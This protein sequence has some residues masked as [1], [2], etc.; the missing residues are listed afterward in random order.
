MKSKNLLKIAAFAVALSTGFV[1]CSSD[2]DADTTTV[3][4]SQ[5]A[6]D[7]ACSDWKTARANWENSEA[8]LFGAA[9]VYSIDPHTDTWPV[10]ANDLA[11]VLRDGISW[12]GICAFPS[13]F[14]PPHQSVDQPRVQ[15]HLC[16]G[17]RPLQRHCHVGS[18]MGLEG[19]QC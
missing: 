4:G 9:D 10:A 13:R 15:L 8:F 19:E 2:D 16:C 5:A 14:A 6:L 3:T 17:Q 18:R 1:S 12:F 7:K 11:D